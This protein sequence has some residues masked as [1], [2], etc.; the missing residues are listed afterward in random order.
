MR[1]T[2][3][4][5]AEQEVLGRK[6][7]LPTLFILARIL[8]TS[9]NSLTSFRQLRQ[10]VPAPSLACACSGGCRFFGTLAHASPGSPPPATP[11]S[12][13][14]LA[15][16]P[17]LLPAEAASPFG[18]IDPV[19]RPMVNPGTRFRVDSIALPSPLGGGLCLQDVS[20][21]TRPLP[22]ECPFF[23]VGDPGSQSMRFCVWNWFNR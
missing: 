8:K 17:P 6:R 3:A 4:S 18:K 12:P 5:N 21:G 9:A 23:G 22:G 7:L 19:G 10:G 14:L 11:A 1:A 13:P 16:F 20:P 2:I 15:F